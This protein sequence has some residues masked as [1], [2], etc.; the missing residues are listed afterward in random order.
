MYSGPASIAAELPQTCFVRRA[1]AD[2]RPQTTSTGP[3]DLRFRAG[4]YIEPGTSMRGASCERSPPSAIKRA[5]VGMGSTSSQASSA[6]SA[7][8]VPISASVADSKA[9]GG[10]ASSCHQTATAAP[11]AVCHRE[12]EEHSSSDG[13]G[14]SCPGRPGARQELLPPRLRTPRKTLSLALWRIR[15]STRK[16][17]RPTWLAL[18]APGEHRDPPAR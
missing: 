12:R 11:V 18:T 5:S 9:L 1:A 16:V 4:R 13:V 3:S 10:L 6:P 7:I 14:S 8:R 15:H 17:H 2:G